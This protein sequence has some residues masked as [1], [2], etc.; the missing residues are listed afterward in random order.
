[1]KPSRLLIRP[2]IAAPFIAAG[3]D[4]ASDPQARV[5][6]AEP[7]VK[8]L[9]ETVPNLPQDPEVVIRA[10]GAIQIGAGL[11]FSIG[12]LRRLSALT[13]FA[14]AGSGTYAYH[15]FWEEGDEQIRA[16]QQAAFIQ[17]VGLLGALL[18]SALDTEGAPSLS[19]R[20]RRAARRAG[21]VAKVGKGATK[22]VGATAGAGLETAKSRAGKAT[23]RARATGDK[24]REKGQAARARTDKFD[25]SKVGE[26]AGRAGE[27]KDLVAAS[28]V[29]DVGGTVAKKV[30]KGGVLAGALKKAT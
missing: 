9:L 22:A 2:M 6:A 21:T 14:T 1:V 16:M 25:F 28:P 30:A 24:A 29:A 18:L 19:W 4:A 8:P 11:L 20:A 23:E 10:T 17:N 5:K 27:L 13:L 12:K 7:V 15:R 26:L 3:V